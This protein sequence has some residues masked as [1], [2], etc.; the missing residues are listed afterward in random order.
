MDFMDIWPLISSIL[1]LAHYLQMQQQKTAIN[2]RWAYAY[3]F[4]FPNLIILVV[5]VG[6]N[7]II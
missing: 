5:V 3:L 2:T 4:A 6:S 1:G 7:K